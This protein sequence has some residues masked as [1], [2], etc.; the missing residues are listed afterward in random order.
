MLKIGAIPVSFL[1]GVPAAFSPLDI[2]GLQ[3]WLKADAGLWQDS[4]GGTPAAS[5][6]DVV[7]AWADQS[8]NARH[9]TQATTSKKPL[10]KLAIQNGRDVVRFDGGDD[11]LSLPWTFFY[12]YFS[13]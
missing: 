13:E 9:A 5:D 3:L 1:S 12:Q 7:G 2:S 11:W 8:G 6:G 10:L 4:V